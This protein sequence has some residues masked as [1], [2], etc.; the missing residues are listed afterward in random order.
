MAIKTA[1]EVTWCSPLGLSPVYDA[2]SLAE[3]A[4]RRHLCHDCG[5]SVEAHAEGAWAYVPAHPI[6]T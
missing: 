6:R 5:A 2:F 3:G 1:D 4:T